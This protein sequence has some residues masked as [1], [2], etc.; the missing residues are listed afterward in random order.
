VAV[1]TAP[2]V[3]PDKVE[4]L[5]GITAGDTLFAPGSR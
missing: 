4:I 5:A 2:T 3:E 1:Q